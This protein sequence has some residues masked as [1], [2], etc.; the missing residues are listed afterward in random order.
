MQV[1]RPRHGK[2]LATLCSHLVSDSDL[3]PWTSS[4]GVTYLAHVVSLLAE[5]ENT[6][7]HRGSVMVSEL[8]W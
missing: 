6:P 2:R 7:F 3:E 1:P 8:C 5:A 4:Q